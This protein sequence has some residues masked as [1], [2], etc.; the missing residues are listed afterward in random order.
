VEVKRAGFWVTLAIILAGLLVFGV[1]NTVICIADP[2]SPDIEV[3]STVSG[4]DN[5]GSAWDWGIYVALG[6]LVVSIA[7]AVWNYRHS[8][9]LFH[10]R[11]YPAV[12]WHKPVASKRGPDTVLTTSICNEGPREITSIFLGLF[13]SRGFKKEAWCRSECLEIRMGEPLDFVITRELEQDIE[14][15]FGGLFY[16]D[17][18]QFEGNPRRYKAIAILEY[19]P[20][21]SGVEP[22]RRKEYY[23]L[24]PLMESGKIKSWE[25]KRIPTWQGHLP[26]F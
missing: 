16:E 18:W 24:T 14:E 10:R 2:S 26:W 23:L 25:P 8:E 9:S 20:L 4:T 1:G 12:L 3:S 13:L 19:L 15:R 17:G 11:E 5:T 7:S 6:A 22:F 21:I